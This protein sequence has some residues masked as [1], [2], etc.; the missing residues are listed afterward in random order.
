MSSATKFEPYA[1]R[2]IQ[3]GLAPE[4]MAKIARLG[5]SPRQQELNRLWATYRG[6]QYDARRIDWDGTERSQGIDHEAIATAG[7]I[8]PGYYDAGA[9]FPIKFRRP[10][11]AYHLRKVIVDRFTG[12]LFTERRHPQL[13]VVD[14]PRTEDYVRTLVDVARIW[15][16]MIQARTYGG[17]MGTVAVGFQF[18]DGKPVV[19]VH[20]PRWC[21]PEFEDR[22]TLRLASIEKRY[23]YPV[24]ERDHETGNWVQRPYWYRRII[25]TE[26]D[27]LFKPVPVSEQEPMWEVSREVIHGLGFCPVVWAQNLPVQDDVDGD[28]DCMGIDDLCEQIDA[29]LS[30]A[31][32]GVIAN[33]DPTLRIITDAELDSL[34]KGSRNALKLPQGSSADYMEMVGTGPKAAL[35]LADRLRSLALEVAQCVLDQPDQVQRT[36]TE[37]ERTYAA[38]LAKADV[39]REQYGERLVKPLVEM[40]LKGARELSKPRAVEGG[41]VRQVLQLP[42]QVTT[43]GDGTVA[44]AARELGEGGIL[45]LSWGPYFAPTLDD[46]MK[47]A[48]SATLAKSGGI[49]DAQ[50]AIAFA[51]PFFGVEDVTAM[52]GAIKAEADAMMASM[53]GGLMGDLNASAPPAEEA[54]ADETGEEMPFAN[55]ALM[56]EG[57]LAGAEAMPLAQTA[58][59]GAQ[60]TSLLEIVNSVASGS[61]PRASG[62]EII[63]Q[64]F[65]LPRATADAMM[66]EVGRSFTLAG[67]G[68][69]QTPMMGEE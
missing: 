27:V 3:S 65:S 9:T 45:E 58:L 59:N 28:P 31:N 7:F 11:A 37:V 2:K 44:R 38:M 14:D 50:H 63:A 18:L 40:M 46:A 1:A 19:E 36:A 54:P 43:N 32:Q 22:H 20:D 24:D 49:V 56:P 6:Q 8:P 48:Q 68:A 4:V 66:G 41:I 33:C 30:Q 21:V 53:D 57:D 5:M 25:D 67:A 34:R 51:A 39:L 16:A 42:M 10:S 12:L 55:E 35:E 26:R 61:L 13:R 47:A 23:M 69:P 62:V 64:S 52:A 60:V 17:A 29:L 15:P